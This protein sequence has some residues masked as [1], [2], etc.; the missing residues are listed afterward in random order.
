MFSIGDKVRYKVESSE[1]EVVGIISA[2]HF[3]CKLTKIGPNPIR[4]YAIGDVWALHVS[5][6]ELIINIFK[7]GDKVRHKIAL[8]EWEIVQVLDRG[9][10]SA[11][12][13]KVVPLPVTDSAYTFH[14]MYL[15]GAISVLA[16]LNL[17]L[18]EDKQNGPQTCT[19]DFIELMRYGCKCGQMERERGI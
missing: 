13:T 2:E 18:L 4:H 1:W 5:N 14:N 16:E 10:Y 8:N 3:H 15:V 19:C 12:C 6:I 17:E 11:K 9:D 7:V